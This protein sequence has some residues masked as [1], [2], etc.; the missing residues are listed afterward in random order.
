MCYNSRPPESQQG[1]VDLEDSCLENV[2][3]KKKAVPSS[4]VS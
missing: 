3:M 2:N 4:W 1:F